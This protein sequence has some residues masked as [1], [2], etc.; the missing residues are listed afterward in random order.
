MQSNPRE[1]AR[2]PMTQET[3]SR[4]T[5]LG[6]AGRNLYD[7]SSP[8][9]HDHERTL[10]SE[11]GIQEPS[12]L[13]EQLVPVF[14][15]GKDV[16]LT[17]TD[18]VTLADAV[19]GACAVENKI[20]GYTGAS[21]LVVDQSSI[22]SVIASGKKLGLRTAQVPNGFDEPSL[23][24]GEAGGVQEFCPSD[25]ARA[26]DV[27]RVLLVAPANIEEDC[28]NS[29]KEI[30]A[31]L[32]KRGKRPQLILIAPELTPTLEL[33]MRPYFQSSA[34]QVKHLFHEVGG[35]LLSKCQALGDFIEGYGLPPTLIFCNQP[36]D[37]DLVE[38]VLRKRG[39]QAR[40]LVGH[41][42]PQKIA[43]VVSQA[44]SGEIT[45]VITTDV[46]GRSV[47]VGEFKLVVNYSIPSDPELYYH[48]TEPSRAGSR[49]REI[50]N[51]VGP[52]DKA[53]FFYLKK[54]VEAPF[55]AAAPPSQDALEKSKFVSFRTRILSALPKE[56]QG[57]KEL[58]ALIMEDSAR[59]EL[60]LA[61]VHI[62]LTPPPVVQDSGSPSEPRG[63]DEEGAGRRGGRDRFERGE[64]GERGDRRERDSGRRGQGPQR[65]GRGGSADESSDEGISASQEQEGEHRS[66]R[67]EPR[68]NP[69]T[70]MQRSTRMYVGKGTGD[71]VSRDSVID[72][73]HGAGIASDSVIHVSIR[74]SYGFIDIEDKEA[75]KAQEA[76]EN[77]SV[78]GD[79]LFT[80]RAV[81]I[82]SQ[83]ELPESVDT[84]GTIEL[85][86]AEL[87][88]HPE[89]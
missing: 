40:K 35:E 85:T 45:A 73:L 23:L 72:L 84:V 9:I 82:T 27:V 41:V 39:I 86:Q 80:R 87:V 29:F 14:R 67:H 42:S 43:Q 15:A 28:L 79:N 77:Y 25:A 50:L 52:L 69:R 5:S 31:T 49:L 61:L 11:L 16:F 53:N 74:P 26:T 10:L 12:L 33:V 83:V 51:I 37:T 48:R 32:C 54:I 65:G 57:V 20:K 63:R 13:L 55:E 7:I 58:L 38:T 75:A 68:N 21:L 71:G 30:L 70:T 17:S 46:A 64:R 36:S 56:T 81:T 89:E 76:L 2:L 59:D 24:V 4:S 66:R 3:P 1:I 88:A 44:A 18:P 34:V 78:R 47:E 6:D 22:A 62:A 19:A 60:L 8:T